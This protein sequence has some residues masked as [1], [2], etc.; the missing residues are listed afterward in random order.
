MDKKT[1]ASIAVS[2]SL[3]VGGV[4][5]DLVPR[6]A[7]LVQAYQYRV[8][9]YIPTYTSATGTVIV[10][11][12]PEF[13]DTDENGLISV[14][15]S[16][17]KKGNKVFEQMD[18]DVY[19]KMT[20]KGGS[21]FNSPVK[22][23]ITAAKALLEEVK[24]KNAEAAVGRLSTGTWGPGGYSSSQ[25]VPITISAGTEVS[26][27]VRWTSNGTGAHDL[28][29][30]TYNGT[31]LTQRQ[32]VTPSGNA[33]ESWTLFAGTT[34]GASHN[35]VLTYSPNDTST[36]SWAA[37]SGTDQSAFDNTNYTTGTSN[38]NITQSITVNTSGSWIISVAGDV[39][40]GNFTAVSGVSEYGSGDVFDSNGT[41]SVGSNSV[42]I[43]RTAGTRAWLWSIWSIKPSA[44]ASPASPRPQDMITFW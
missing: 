9:T 31:A 21:Q 43:N 16:Y 18:D 15:M 12:Q 38:G 36:G 30:I 24:M 2:T 3:L 29:G 27:F 10:N 34:D 41:A 40:T 17:D 42:T 8:E 1:L 22:Y 13:Y 28:T 20:E 23:K 44:S 32:S 4:T 7:P 39:D 14:K 11:E 37:Y 35:L 25:T 5:V 6:E 33:I 26:L 19:T